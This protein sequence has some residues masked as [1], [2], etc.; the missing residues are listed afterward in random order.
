MPPKYAGVEPNLPFQRS[1]WNGSHARP[2]TAIVPSD[3]NAIA[4]SLSPVRFGAGEVIVPAG[5]AHVAVSGMLLNAVGP[6]VACDGPPRPPATATATAV[7]STRPA[8]RNFRFVICTPRYR[9]L[10]QAT[11]PLR[12]S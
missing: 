2:S 9:S 8:A 3:A 1:T 6:A 5:A 7:A 12:D 4:G 10:F 11:I